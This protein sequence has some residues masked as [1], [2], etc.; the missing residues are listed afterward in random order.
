M[1]TSNRASQ[2][3]ASG[4]RR[5]TTSGRDPRRTRNAILA[6]AEQEFAAGGV[7]AA[8]TDRIASA[9]GVNKALLYYYFK[10]KESLYGAVLDAAFSQVYV[11]L[12]KALDGPGSP[13]EC[14]L[15]Y[16]AE[17]FDLLAGHPSL[18]RVV[19]HEM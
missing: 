19:L 15:R 13:Q 18:P 17:H 9:A 6:A 2:P 12:T 3:Q 4:A 1:K 7:A 16:A 14:V 5:R 10:D 11:R 8:R